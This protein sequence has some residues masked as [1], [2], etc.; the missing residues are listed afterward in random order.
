MIKALIQWSAV[1]A[2]IAGAGLGVAK[3]MAPPIVRDLGD[4]AGDAFARGVARAQAQLQR[5]ASA[6]VS[7]RWSRFS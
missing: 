7:G 5:E 3:L 1:G 2:C 4:E 6:M